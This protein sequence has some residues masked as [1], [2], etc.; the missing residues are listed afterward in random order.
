MARK[1]PKYVKETGNSLGYQ[2]AVPT[3]LQ[4]IAK[5]RLYSY[6]LGLSFSGLMHRYTEPWQMLMKLSV[7]SAKRWSLAVQVPTQKTK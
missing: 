7:Y 5:K 2:R 4:H 3:R 1:Y 6:P